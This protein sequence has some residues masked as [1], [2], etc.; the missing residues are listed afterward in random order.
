MCH[1]KRNW[2]EYNRKLVNRGNLF[3]WI[4]KTVLNE[5][6]VKKKKRGHTAFSS[7]V[8][9]TGW[10]LKTFYRCTLRSLQGFLNSLL[11]LMQQNLSSPHYSVFCRRAAQAAA[12]LPKLSDRKPTDLVIDSSGLKIFGE[13]EWKD[14]VHRSHTRKSWIKL[15]LALDPKS[16]E[17]ITSVLTDEKTADSSAVSA[18]LEQSPQSIHKL[19][20]DGAYD[21]KSVRELLHQKGIDPCMGVFTQ[22]CQG[23]HN[24]IAPH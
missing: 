11:Q 8:I 9:Q 16:Q 2:Q 20:A 22:L 5:G 6:I 15:H 18:L 3:L 1:A 21:K 23:T 14:K 10:F 19:L 7:S 24:Y 4:D 12:L 17:I 13:G